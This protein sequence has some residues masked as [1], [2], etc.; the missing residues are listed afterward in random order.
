M[1]EQQQ[2]EKSLARGMELYNQLTESEKQ[3][4]IERIKKM[5]SE[6]AEKKKRGK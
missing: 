1:T 5:L 2:Q 4:I 6:K 3:M